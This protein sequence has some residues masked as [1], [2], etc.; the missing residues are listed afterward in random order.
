MFTLKTDNDRLLLASPDLRA[1]IYLYGGL[2]NR[3]EIRRPDGTWFNIVKA[4]DTPQHARESLTEWF[5]SGKLSPYA[6]RLRHGKYSFDG[7]AYQ[8]G[9]FKLA[10]HAAHGL[11]YDREFAL[12]NSHADG[13]SA[14]VE[15]RADYAQDDSGYPFPFSLTVRYRLSADGLSIRST[16]RNQGATAMPLADGW[17]PYF[18]LGGKTDDWSLEIDSSKRLGFDADLVPDGSMI[19]DTRFQTTSS[20]AGIELDNS[21][22]LARSKPAAC[23]LS[24]NGLTLSIYPDASYPYLQIFTPSTRDTIAIENLS[25]APDCFNNGLGLIKLN[26]GEEAVFETRYHIAANR[27]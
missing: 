11:M 2:L 7:K 8:C 15:I 10:E 17:H 22:V 5:R 27:P 18:T 24:G 6:C 16:V 12:V 21:F 20:L 1:E 14:E 4:Y 9:K 25:G 19:D 26:A 23:T 13:Q 3:Y